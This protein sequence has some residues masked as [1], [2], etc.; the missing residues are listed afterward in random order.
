VFY[1]TKVLEDK[2]ISYFEGASNGYLALISDTQRSTLSANGWSLSGCTSVTLPAN[3]VIETP[4][5]SAPTTKVTNNVMTG[6]TFTLSSPALGKM[7]DLRAGVGLTTSFHLR[8]GVKTTTVD[9]KLQYNNGS[10]TNIENST[11]PIPA[12]PVARWLFFSY[13]FRLDT[14][15]SALKNEDF[16]IVISITDTGSG[17]PQDYV[18]YVNGLSVGQRSESVAVWDMGASDAYTLNSVSGGPTTLSVSKYNGMLTAVKSGVPLHR[19]MESATLLEPW[20]PE[21][22]SLTM[23]KGGFM[24]EANKEDVVTLEFWMKIGA[25]PHSPVRIVGPVGSKEGLYLTGTTLTLSLGNLEVGYDVGTIDYPMLIDWVLSPTYSAVLVNGDAV[26]NLTQ[27]MVKSRYSSTGAIGFYTD[28]SIHPMYV[29]SIATY[30]YAV[31]SVVAKIRFVRGQG[32]DQ[33][34]ITASKFDGTSFSADF[35]MSNF[36][37]N[38]SYPDNVSWSKGQVNNLVATDKISL[39]EYDMPNMQNQDIE[40]DWSALNG[41]MLSKPTPS[42]SYYSD[43]FP[44]DAANDNTSGTAFTNQ[45][46]NGEVYSTQTAASSSTNSIVIPAGFPK[47]ATL[48]LS[49]EAKFAGTEPMLTVTFV[50]PGTTYTQTFSS[51][52]PKSTA[53][54]TQA[55]PSGTTSITWGLKTNGGT[56][57]AQYSAVYAKIVYPQRP[58]Y[59]KPTGYTTEPYLSWPS[60]NILDSDT[61]ESVV[62][63]M[64]VGTSPPSAT[65]ILVLQK[66]NTSTAL[67]AYLNGTTLTY[68]YSDYKGATVLGTKTIAAN[69]HANVGFDIPELMMKYPNM[70]SLLGSP[71]DV[72]VIVAGSDGNSFTGGIYHVSFYSAWSKKTSAPTFTDGLADAIT[73]TSPIAI[74]AASYSLVAMTEYGNSTL[75]IISSG[76]WQETIPVSLLAQEVTNAVGERVSRLDFIQTTIGKTRC[77]PPFLADEPLTYFQLLSRYWAKSYADLAS[78]YATYSALSGVTLPTYDPTV[79]DL[80]TWV[81]LGKLTSAPKDYGDYTEAK[82]DGNSTVFLDDNDYVNFVQDGNSLVI[83][84]PYDPDQYALTF[85]HVLRSRGQ[86][87]VPVKLKSFELASWASDYAEW[88]SLGTQEGESA[89]PYTHNGS[90]YTTE[91]PSIFEVTKRG[92]NYL[93]KSNRSGFKPKSLPMPGYDSG[94]AFGWQRQASTPEPRKLGGVSVWMMLDS[95]KILQSV[96]IMTITIGADQECFVEAVPIENGTRYALQVKTSNGAYANSQ[97]SINGNVTGAPIL[98]ARE[99]NSIQLSFID[100]VDTDGEKVYVRVSGNTDFAFDHVTIH[101][102][103]SAVINGIEAHR[104]WHEL[105][106]PTPPANYWSAW[107]AYTWYSL[108]NIGAVMNV[109]MMFD[110]MVAELTGTGVVGGFTSSLKPLF[111]EVFVLRDIE[112]VDVPVITK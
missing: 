7:K 71:G 66:K 109:D 57:S 9:I 97:W 1:Q 17:A 98:R 34:G 106:T 29:S 111:G 47:G 39:P 25:P 96:K 43:I 92:H 50:G 89:Y 59:V 31:P 12:S 20:L 62:V 94:I 22:P 74:E 8:M 42:A 77:T 3:E 2:P 81:A 69:T 30:Q 83:P 21:R 48:V 10:W 38:I 88:R 102:Q 70:S 101:G 95:V 13:T 60:L 33:Y 36:A 103:L 78:D 79:L 51:T 26:I 5:T 24:Q 15:A 91:F 85:Y 76:Y 73:S 4:P 110:E 6:S 58:F 18:Y 90:Y 37:T 61:V 44:L 72:E 55:I 107:G 112:W 75:D 52:N 32:T 49:G 68:E 82:Y 16:R 40:K 86:R 87:S 14:F 23:Q 28:E 53:R 104:T 108:Y 11:V 105:T 80:Q 19:S 46:E 67:R 64:A 100:P 84:Y 65:N 99:W 56:T 54:L 93:Y 45:A 27:P 41:A 63:R 35:S